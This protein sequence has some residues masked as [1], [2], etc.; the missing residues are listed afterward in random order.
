M[1]EIDYEG[2]ESLS[3]VRT[4]FYFGDALP[5]A[6]FPAAFAEQFDAVS[7]D[8]FDDDREHFLAH[9][10]E[11]TIV[12]YFETIFDVPGIRMQNGIIAESAYAPEGAIIMPSGYYA[13]GSA[14]GPE[15]EMR[16]LVNLAEGTGNYGKIYVWYLAH[17]PL[18]EGDNT[19]GL[20]F[21]ANSLNGFI[22]ALEEEGKLA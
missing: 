17:D 15:N 5:R 11:G 13:F 6:S 20:G 21:V 1:S 22:A 4:D 3:S 2:V 16:L 12:C 8:S 9:F 18:G 10:S 14:H 19:R 7:D